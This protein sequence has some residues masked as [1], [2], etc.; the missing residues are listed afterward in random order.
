MAS[1]RDKIGYVRDGFVRK[2]KGFTILG[3]ITDFLV[4]RGDF[5]WFSWGFEIWDW[6]ME[7]VGFLSWCVD[8]VAYTK[9]EKL[10]MP[11][12]F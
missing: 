1:W 2:I 7:E 5:G 10:V 6:N 8:E 11:N 9:L 4:E 3:S 12:S